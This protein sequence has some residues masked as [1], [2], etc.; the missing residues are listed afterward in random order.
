[1]AYAK[2]ATQEFGIN[3]I[4]FHQADIVELGAL[5]QQFDLIISSGVLHHMRDP[6]A[7]WRNLVGLLKPTGYM[8]IG[9]YSRRA[10]HEVTRVRQLIRERGYASTLDGIRQFRFDVMSENAPL[11]IGSLAMTPDFYST[12]ACRDLVFH[13]EEHV[14]SPIEIQDCLQQLGLEF[15]GFEFSNPE[16]LHRY[17]ERFPENPACNLLENWDAL[18]TES[19][20]IFA[21]MYQFWVRKIN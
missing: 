11:D 19:P 5:D 6:L 10:R 21:G 13:V 4:A 7:G 15:L 16:A 14:F 9:L 12:S 3:N 1:L 2:R 8:N 17:A 18:E 20:E